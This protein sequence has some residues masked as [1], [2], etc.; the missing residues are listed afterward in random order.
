MKLEGL[1]QLAKFLKEAVPTHEESISTLK[2]VASPLVSSLRAN[3]PIDTGN[4]SK[5]FQVYVSKKRTAVVVGPKYGKNG[6]NH[7]HLI[8]YGW[9]KRN[10]EIQPGNPFIRKTYDMMSKGLE[11][12]LQKGFIKLIENKAK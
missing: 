6:G 10:G 9:T 7:A 8:E 5:S 2:V 12:S 1:E 3:A 4:L 11:E